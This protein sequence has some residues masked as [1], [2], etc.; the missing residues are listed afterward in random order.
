MHRRVAHTTAAVTPHTYSAERL[1]R[2][3]DPARVVPEDAATKFYYSTE[4]AY[5]AREESSELGGYDL[6]THDDHEQHHWRR[7]DSRGESILSGLD[8]PGEA[9]HDRIRGSPESM[10]QGG[11]LNSVAEEDAGSPAPTNPNDPELGP[12]DIEEVIAWELEENGLYGG[13]S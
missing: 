11:S 12:E 6:T 10:L 5:N 2:L 8:G 3:H 1:A 9:E 7:L 4:D 13:E